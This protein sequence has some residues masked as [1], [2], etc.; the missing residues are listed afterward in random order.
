[1]SNNDRTWEVDEGVDW[2]NS[3]AL[4]VSIAAAAAERMLLARISV[5][6]AKSVAVEI[7]SIVRAVVLGSLIAT[8]LA[9]ATNEVGSTNMML[10]TGF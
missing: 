8:E 10:T 3:V 9:I 5:D 1:M 6:A 2:K 7:I 4:V